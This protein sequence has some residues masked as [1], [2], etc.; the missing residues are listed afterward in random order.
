MGRSELIVAFDAID[1]SIDKM[2]Q[3]GKRP[4]TAVVMTRR[5]RAGAPSSRTPASKGSNA[6]GQK[7]NNYRFGGV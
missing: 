6:S 4:I 5:Y 1:E 7:V 3:H 2:R